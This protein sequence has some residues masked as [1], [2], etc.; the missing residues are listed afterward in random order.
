MKYLIFDNSL[1]LPKVIKNNNYPVCTFIDLEI[2][3][4]HDRQKG[5]DCF[6][7]DHTIKDLRKISLN[8]KPFDLGV[9][10]NALG[11]HSISEINEVIEYGAT[12]IMLPMFE[13]PKEVQ[14]VKR[15][16]NGR[17]KFDLLFETPKSIKDFKSFD[18][19]DVDRVHIGLNDLTIAL[20]K[21]QIY[22]I[23]VNGYLDQI[24]SFFKLNNI[25]FGIGGIGSYNTKPFSPKYIFASNIIYNSNF[26]ILSRSFKENLNFLSYEQLS[27]TFK[28]EFN[29]LNTLYKELN[30]LH[31]S[32]LKKIRSEFEMIINNSLIREK[33]N[34]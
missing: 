1:I 30:S 5:L 22:E 4:K 29:R 17:A 24:T 20:G 19:K 27:E 6:I 7:S 33:I 13:S 9:R 31:N 11:S 28:Y 2:I 8:I 15:I 32:E 21:K 23:L 14:E 25:Q 34:I 3:G 12:R 10:I 16:I 18:Y 26:I